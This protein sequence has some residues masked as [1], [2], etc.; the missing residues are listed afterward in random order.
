[1]LRP[2]KAM[3]AAARLGFKADIGKEQ[4]DTFRNVQHSDLRA[5]YVLADSS[6]STNT[7]E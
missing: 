3:S 4:A 6:I 2:P 7:K 5:D 1:M